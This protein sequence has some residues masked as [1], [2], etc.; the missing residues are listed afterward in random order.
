[1]KKPKEKRRERLPVHRD[2]KRPK[3][4]IQLDSQLKEQDKETVIHRVL[5][6]TYEP[7]PSWKYPD[8]TN[9]LV[10][11]RLEEPLR[12]CKTWLCLEYKGGARWYAEQF[13]ARRGLRCPIGAI[14]GVVRLE[15]RAQIPAQVELDLSG[16]YPRVVAEY[17]VWQGLE[18]EEKK[19][20]E[21]S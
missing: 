8:K 12:I 15:K 21:I 2:P 11:Y 5:G 6:I 20:S 18:E 19:T 16:E 10:T 9:I 17:F 13:F 4:F 3:R 7:T 1:M 14:K